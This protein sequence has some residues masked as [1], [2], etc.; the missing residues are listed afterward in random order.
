[1]PLALASTQFNLKYASGRSRRANDWTRGVKMALMAS[2]Q[3]LG[4]CVTA[5]RFGLIDA[6]WPLKPLEL[7]SSRHPTIIVPIAHVNA[8]RAWSKGSEG[9]IVLPSHV[10]FRTPYEHLTCSSDPGRGAA[11][12]RCSC[13]NPEP[14]DLLYFIKLL[15]SAKLN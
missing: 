4:R 1:M 14:V 2:S 9:S 12:K 3:P 5:Q 7:A 10:L 11:N 8:G 15:R 6:S 13:G